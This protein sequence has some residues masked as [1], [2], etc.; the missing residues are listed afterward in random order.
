MEETLYDSRGRPVAYIADD[1]EMSIYLWSGYAVAYIS[2][3]DLYGWNGHHIGWF[4]NGVLYN[5]Q[6]QRAGFI[7][8]RCPSALYAPTAKY[9][10][11]A[12]Y[13]KSARYA[14]YARPALSSGY[15]Q[16]P[17]E[18]FLKIGAIGRI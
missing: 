14:A 16:E 2:G 9:A 15:S 13:A 10:K 8:G 4:V 17:F 11:Y 7:G 18:E 3:E 6:G 12:K 5:R 1:G